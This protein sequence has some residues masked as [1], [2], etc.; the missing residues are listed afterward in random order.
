LLSA[1]GVGDLHAEVLLGYAMQWLHERPVLTRE[2]IQAALTP[3]AVAGTPL[4]PR[5]GRF[6]PGRSVELVKITPEYS[7]P[8]RCPSCG[9][10]LKPACGDRRYRATVSWSKPET[11]ARAAAGC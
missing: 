4:E 1:Y 9:Q 7:I 10:P 8:R 2:S 5:P 3:S 11:S 6:G